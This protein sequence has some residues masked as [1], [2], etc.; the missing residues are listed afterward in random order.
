MSHSD[1]KKR[2]QMDSLSFYRS[3]MVGKC[4]PCS[5]MIVFETLDF[6]TPDVRNS[7]MTTECY[8]LSFCCCLQMP[9]GGGVEH[10]EQSVKCLALGL[11]VHQMPRV[12]PGWG[13]LT[14]GIDSHKTLYNS[15]NIG[16]HGQ[17][18]FWTWLKKKLLFFKKLWT[19]YT[20]VFFL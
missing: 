8:V 11:I 20:R 4:S 2:K 5:K 3:F 13:M 18:N 12:C 15:K 14:V 10:N 9:G 7:E 6:W 17:T 19:E 1:Q 16:G